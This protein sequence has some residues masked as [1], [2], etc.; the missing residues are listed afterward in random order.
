MHSNTIWS[1]II[2]NMWRAGA[3]WKPLPIVFNSNDMNKTIRQNY[4]PPRIL[5][6]V[7]IH[8]ELDLLG[9][10]NWPGSG[11]EDIIWD[12]EASGENLIWDTEIS[13]EGIIW[14]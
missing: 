10:S 11:G 14:D 1:A 13:G 12:N 5:E 9:P 8:L 2:L 7:L 4:V 6:E 3:N